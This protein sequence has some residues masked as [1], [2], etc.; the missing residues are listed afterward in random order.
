MNITGHGIYIFVH[1]HPQIGA[2]LPSQDLRAANN[3]PP[4]FNIA[5]SHRR[6]LNVSF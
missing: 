1:Y 6:D 2:D 4:L 3:P 5:R